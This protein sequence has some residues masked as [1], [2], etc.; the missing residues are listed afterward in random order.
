MRNYIYNEYW[1]WLINESALKFHHFI[2]VWKYQQEKADFKRANRTVT[3]TKDQTEFM[4]NSDSN[5]LT[6]SDH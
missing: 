3:I 1:L 5:R 6:H 4:G 2:T